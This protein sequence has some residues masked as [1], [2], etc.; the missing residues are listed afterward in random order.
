MKGLMEYRAGKYPI[1]PSAA[2]RAIL[3]AVQADKIGFDWVCFG[4][5]PFTVS[6]N[7]L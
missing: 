2:L 6:K 3:S 1:G 4:F 7:W 5:A